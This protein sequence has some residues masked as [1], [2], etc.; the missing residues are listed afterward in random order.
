MEQHS[1]AMY[2]EYFILAARFLLAWTFIEYG[3][4]KL[5]GGQ[6]GI[7]EA[8]MAQPVE[9]LSLFKLAWYLSD[10]QPFKAFIGITQILCGGLLIWNRTAFLG[11]FMFIPIALGILIFDLTYMPYTLAKGFAWRFGFYF[12]LV[13]LILWYYRSILFTIWQAAQS[14]LKGQNPFPY[15]AYALLPVAAIVLEFLGIMPRLLV[16]FIIDPA[17]YTDAM[18]STLAKIPEYWE[19]FVD[20][21]LNR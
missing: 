2:R 17:T 3:I 19:K 10:Q 14:R 1:K 6:F 8:E 13:F 12:L 15:W 4:S 7:S 18:L 5:T 11:T 16:H 20:A 21:Y 9:E